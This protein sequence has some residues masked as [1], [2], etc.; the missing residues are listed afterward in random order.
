MSLKLIQRRLPRGAGQTGVALGV[1]VLLGGALAAPAAAD[2]PLFGH[3]YYNSNYAAEEHTIN[4]SNASYLRRSWETFNDDTFVGEPTPTGFILEGALALVFPGPV[5]GVI[6]SPIVHDGTIYYVDELGTVFARDAQTGLMLDPGAH[7]TTT[8]NDPDFAAG[9]PPIAPEL[10]YTSPIV[11][12]DDIWVVGAVYGRVH[13]VARDGG[14]EFDFDPDTPGID[15]LTLVPDRPVAS[16]L[17]DPVMVQWGDQTLLIV[18]INVIVNDALFQEGETGLIIAYDV[19]NPDEPVEAWRRRTIDIDPETGFPYGTGVSAGAGMAVDLERGYIFGGTGQNTSAPYEEYPD[20][21][22][23][24]DGYVDRGDSV[25]VI[26]LDTGDYVWTNQFHEGDVFD[27]NDPVGTGPTNPDGPRDADVLAPPVLFSARVR[28]QWRDLVGDGTKGGIFRVMDRETGETI[29]TRKISKRT[30]IGGI[31]GGAA[32]ADGV[33]YVAGYEGID[34][35]FSDEQFGVSLDTGIYPNAFFATFAPAFWADVEDTAMDDNPATGM[36]TKVYALDAATGRS[37]W[38][39]PHNVDYVPLYAGSSM[40]HVSVTDDLVFVATSSGQLF[41]LDKYTGA[42][43]FHDQSPDLNEVFDLGL[44]KP[45]HGAM[46]G[47]TVIA[48]GMLFVP[49]GGQNNP[50]GG[51]LAY[52]L[53]E[54]PIAEDDWF[55]APPGGST[56]LDALGNDSDPNGDRLRFVEVAGSDIDVDDGMPDEIYWPYGTIVV[57]NPGDDPDDPDAAYLQFTPASNFKGVRMIGY[58]VEDMAPNLIVN[59]VEVDEPNPTHTPRTAEARIRL[60]STGM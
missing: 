14:A 15:P 32:F 56:I 23:A 10:F 21:D 29:W 44:G 40:R 27:L 3:D 13:R 42:I 31:Q 2:W 58:A 30:G 49:Y 55:A 24:P 5:A 19:T 50:S 35:L 22:F 8:L 1:A 39:F 4:D 45:H 52:E 60:V 51:V 17:G 7:W 33:L 28:G 38:R 43:L 54:A 59:G 6:G 25:W 34:D 18:V 11:T 46:N 53:N 41:V 9:D 47:G 57:V 20:P 48:D 37:L 26:D 36:R 16:V 12:D